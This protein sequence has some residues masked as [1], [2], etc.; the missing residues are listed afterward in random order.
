MMK[1]FVPLLI[2]IVLLVAAC[3]SNKEDSKK[4][5]KE[6]NYLDLKKTLTKEG[7]VS[8][9]LTDVTD[10]ISEKSIVKAI[11]V[12]KDGKE[13][14]YRANYSDDEGV[15][16]KNY[17]GKTDEEIIKAAKRNEKIIINDE[18][19]YVQE[20]AEKQYR[21][22]QRRHIK[23]LLDST[24]KLKYE[25]AKPRKLEY[26]AS[27]EDGE[28]YV[29]VNF[30]PMHLKEVENPKIEGGGI[31]KIKDGTEDVYYLEKPTKLLSLKKDQYIGFEGKTNDD[32]YAVVTKASK[33]T[34][35]VTSGLKEVE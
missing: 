14:V 6:D 11:V 21:S 19:E 8:F 29:Y 22:D 1:R 4:V 20:K 26:K 25:E 31:Y 17:D 18:I 2:I 32:Y 5:E 15:P 24:E 34:E 7:N 9:V 30:V 23:G 35:G 16:L 27:K 13:F 12:R 28:S 33:K 3:S 10:E